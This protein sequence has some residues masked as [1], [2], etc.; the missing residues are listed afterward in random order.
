MNNTL[1]NE[2][3]IFTR[4]LYIKDEVE[5]ALLTNIL[6]K[7]EESVFWAYELYFSG[8][9]KEVFQYLWDIYYNFFSVLNPCFESYFLKK[10]KEWNKTKNDTIIY[11]LVDNLLIR[12]FNIDVFILSRN[13]SKINT[14]TNIN[15]K[16]EKTK[17]KSWIQNINYQM[18]ANYILHLDMDITKMYG[19]IIDIFVELFPNIDFYKQK[20][21]S[22]F[23]IMYTY[24]K[25]NTININKILLSKVISLFAISNNV[26]QGK[27]FYMKVEPSQV[28]IYENFETKNIKLYKL[29]NSVCLFGVNDNHYLSLFELHRNKINDIRD[30]YHNHWLYYAS[31]SPIWKKRIDDF[32]GKIDY[33]KK[34]INFENEDIEEDFYNKYNYEPDEQSNELKNKTIPEIIPHYDLNTFY[35]IFSNHN[36]I[37]DD[38]IFDN[39][40]KIEINI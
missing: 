38:T 14:E 6:E 17:L 22:Q 35:K 8:F 2:D 18:I 10:E 30:A 4:Y 36:I 27:N 20:L 11:I 34:K 12:P 40:N 25:I 32:S 24:H 28:V 23:K 33:E 13:S 9:Q 37:K 26:I 21:L 31:F 3:I 16:D 15:I 7:K 1:N 5:I 29:L 39:I 19:I